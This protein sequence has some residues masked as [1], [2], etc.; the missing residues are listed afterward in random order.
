[1]TRR[2]N[3]ALTARIVRTVDGWG[4]GLTV[5]LARADY[6]RRTG[7]DCPDDAQV[8]AVTPGTTC[9]PGGGFRGV[10]G[11]YE[12]PADITDDRVVTYR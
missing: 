7:K 4:Y 3:K 9:E 1:M 5:A 8:W 10:I 2:I 11:S 12:Q 6:R